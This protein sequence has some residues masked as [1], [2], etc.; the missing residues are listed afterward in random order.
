[1]CIRDRKN[2]AKK[3][4]KVVSGKGEAKTNHKTNDIPKGSRR[5]HR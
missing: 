3:A 4:G 5:V 2:A 1:M